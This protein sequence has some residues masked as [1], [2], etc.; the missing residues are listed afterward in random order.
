MQSD[1]ARAGMLLGM[2]SELSRA[3]VS[4][5]VIE[6]Y[7]VRLEQIGFERV[8]PVLTKL[9]DGDERGVRWPSVA[10]IENLAS[11]AVT[12][13]HLA[14]QIAAKIIKSIKSFGYT[15]QERAL[16]TAGPIASRVI[17]RYGGWSVICEFC[18][19]ETVFYAQLRDLACSEIRV[20]T[21]EE[22][23][24]QANADK[25]VP[26]PVQ[27][28]TPLQSHREERIAELGDAKNHMAMILAR[29]RGGV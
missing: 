5:A 13:E 11:K 26:P 12:E 24:A 22:R 15:N 10:Q 27:A 8:L 20:A 23:V 4:V 28:W 21:D 14:R 29:F 7:L 3:N 16:A 1:R 6:F 9:L 25:L 17:D 2:L 18:G 19:E